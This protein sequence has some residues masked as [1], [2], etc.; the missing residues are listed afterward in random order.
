[1]INAALLNVYFILHYHSI[2]FFIKKFIF[3]NV[4]ISVNTI[5]EYIYMIFGW[6]RGHQLSMCATGRGRGTGGRMGGHPKWVKLRIGGGSVTPHVYVRTY[7][8][9]FHVFGSIL[10]YSVLFYLYKFNFIFNQKRCVHQKR[11]F[12]SKKINF[13]RTE[14]SLFS[15]KLFLRSKVSQMLLIL[16][17]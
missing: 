6:E 2:Y 7:N 14:I 9:S 8:I 12:F 4:Y 16:I 3:S 5:S 17:K 11:L 15:L 1:M 10:S 13:C